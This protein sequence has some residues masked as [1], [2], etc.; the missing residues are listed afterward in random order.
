MKLNDMMHTHMC[1]ECMIKVKKKRS[2]KF[3]AMG[4]MYV[5]DVIHALSCYRT[6]MYNDVQLT[7][8]LTDS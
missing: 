1:Y 8:S 6:H 5:H 2:F 7:I 4:L 3:Q